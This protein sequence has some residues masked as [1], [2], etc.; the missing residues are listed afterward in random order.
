MNAVIYARYSSH[1]QTEQSIEGQLHDAY[2]W[3]AQ[4]EITVVGEYID[5]AL[6]GTKDARPD[7]LRMIADASRHQFEMVIVW[8]LDRFARNRYDSAI[9]KAK[10]K[11]QGV[12]VVSVKENITDTPEGIILE[13]LLE[14]MAEYYSANLSQNVKRGQRETI[15]KG[16]FIGGVI[17]YGYNVS[18]GHLVINEKAA[19]NVRYVFEQYASGTSKKMLV[20][21]LNRRGVRNR[22]GLPVTINFFNR[23]FRNPVYTGRYYYHGEP[24]PGVAERIIDDE[25]FEK[26]QAKLSSTARAPAARK[27]KVDYLLQGKAFC[28]HCGAPMVGESGRNHA[29]I[30]YNYYACANKKKLHTCSK[31]NEKKDD[32]EFCIASQTREG[33]L[34][35]SQAARVARLVVAEYNREFSSSRINELEKA[36]AQL[37]REMEKLI[38]AMLSVPKAAQRSITARMESVGQQMED[39][40]ADLARLRIAS[41][42]G[43][44]ES[45][46]CSWLHALSHGDP[47]DPAYQKKLIDTFIHSIYVYDD[48]M[49]I[50]Y[51][52]PPTPSPTPKSSNFNPSASP[53]NFKFEPGYIFVNGIFGYVFSKNI[54]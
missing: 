13:G 38:D 40:E 26:V 31:K 50:L 21:E 32:L 48:H 12:R 36:I 11:K 18:D 24:I 17:P 49:T 46:V 39:M 34:L 15:A 2:A 8:K 42:L 52:L 5:R 6:T 25:I 27:A 47:H 16:R 51:N 23:L 20:E 4:Q 19:P 14:S 1:G 35:P 22:N 54:N 30:I 7:F 43:I 44:T 53:E 28:G 37:Q 9:Y 41:R 29:G 33:I 45:D 3:A 10:L